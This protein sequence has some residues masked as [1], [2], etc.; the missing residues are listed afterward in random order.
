MKKALISLKVFR[1]I[2]NH[3]KFEVANKDL[4]L[5]LYISSLHLLL[6]SMPK[7]SEKVALIFKQANFKD[8]FNS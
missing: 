5:A 1:F 6:M 3:I 2:K 8:I 7:I 4:V